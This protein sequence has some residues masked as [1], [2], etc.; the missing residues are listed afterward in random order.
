MKV[1]TYSALQQWNKILCKRTTTGSV[2]HSEIKRCN[3]VKFN[4][5]LT[6]SKATLTSD[7][8]KLYMTPPLQRRDSTQG[9][10]SLYLKGTLKN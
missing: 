6:L 5:S 7:F 2:F 4:V 10:L 9:L 8:T 3:S 1:A